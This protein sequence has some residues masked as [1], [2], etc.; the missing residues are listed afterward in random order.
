MKCNHINLERI[1]QAMAKDILFATI[2][3][4]N[5]CNQYIMKDESHGLLLIEPQ[6]PKIKV[7]LLKVYTILLFTILLGWLIGS[8]I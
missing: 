6:L 8:I 5:D 3:Y 4:C 2:Y 7:P 1:A